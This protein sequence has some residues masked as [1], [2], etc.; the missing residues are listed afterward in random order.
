MNPT[1]QRALEALDTDR[2]LAD[3]AGLIPF[4][5]LGGEESE[6]QE[7]MAAL[8][9]QA[10]LEVDRWDIDMAE[11]RR[12]PAWTAEIDRSEAVGVV[13]T[14]GAGEGPTLILNGHV[15][16]VPVGD[17]DLWSVP[18]WEATCTEGRVYGRGSA[19]MKG[20]LCCALSAVR[21]IRDAG[22]RLRGRV[23]L[24]SVVGEEDG[25]TGTLA[26]LLRGH[27]G[28]GAVVMEPTGLMLAPS[29]AGALNF[30]LTIPGRAAHGALR[31]EGIDPFEK[32][33]LLHQAMRAFEVRRGEATDDP[34]FDDYA[35]PFPLSVGRIRSGTW[36]S[37]VP[38]SL[39][40]EGR[41]GFGA[42]EE[43]SEVRGAFE[44][45][46]AE[47]ASCDPWLA[48][49]PP[50]VTWWGAQFDPA[51]T[52]PE[53]PIVTILAGAHDEVIG[54]DPVLQG[55]PF[56]ADMRLLANT[57]GI[58]AVLY[59]PGDIRRAHA[60][61]EYVPVAE[62]ET[63]ARSLLLTILRFCGSER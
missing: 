15:D 63:A 62:L 11:V 40:V 3:L 38:E 18:P 27:T 35:I 45:A 48:D 14:L 16:V 39:T 57:G 2:L 28:D 44:K 56:G 24:Q 49:H 1:E 58:P 12:H 29:H 37:N 5:S 31:Y 25:G 4:R 51:A 21:A 17:E 20:A 61:D 7:R 34:L 26:T 9:E 53:D 47:A 59:G 19:D 22:I 43:A 36:A 46:I 54:R 30:R 52:D 32:Y 60:P 55:M 13:G 50:N 42:G 6:I 41:L 33:L 10:G 23:Q 8:M